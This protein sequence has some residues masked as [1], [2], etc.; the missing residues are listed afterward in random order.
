MRRLWFVILPTLLLLAPAA[1]GQEALYRPQLQAKDVDATL[2]PDWYGVYLKDQKVG[3]VR[4][5]RKREGDAI[6]EQQFTALKLLSF[7]KK[8]EMTFVQKMAFEARAPYRLTSAELLQSSG[9]I[10]QKTTFTRKPSGEIEAVHRVGS[11]ARHVLLKDIDYT[12]AD[13]MAV[14]QWVKGA[15]KPGDQIAVR[16]F[17]LSDQKMDVQTSKVLSAKDSLVG[18]VQLKVFE[19]EMNSKTKDIKVLGRYDDQGNT[20]SAQIIIFEMR[21]ETEQQARNFDYS[22]DLF[23]MGMVKLD[24]KMGEHP[25]RVA[26]LVLEVDG[27]DADVFADGPR[28]K[29]VADNGKRVVKLGKAHGKAVKATKEE[30][31]AA[32]TETNNYPISHPKIKALAD[33]VVAGATTPEEKVKKIVSYVHDFI[34]PALTANAPNIH[35]LLEKKQGDCKSYALMVTNLARAAGVP[36]REVSGLLYVG[37]DFKAFGGHA[38]NEVVLDGV[39]VPVDASMNETEVSATHISFGTEHQATKNLLTALGKLSFKLVQVN[40]Q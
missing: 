37:D 31:E 18:G 1:R 9:P 21:K 16:H 30:I 14:E 24:R 33:K 29:V 22:Q 10:E 12:L 25:A 19:L 13:S 36:A 28:Q 17:D 2:K 11:E 7:G 4:S 27:K 3:Y 34:K 26:E 35:D 39:W 8:A 32:L 40:G 38:W 20:L 23:V 15:P 6:V 5:E